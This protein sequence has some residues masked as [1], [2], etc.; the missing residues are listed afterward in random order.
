MTFSKKSV[1]LFTV[2]GTGHN[3][4]YLNIL[5]KAMLIKEYHITV[6]L[7]QSC[8]DKDSYETYIKPFKEHLN[9]ILHEDKFSD[10][11]FKN[12]WSECQSL[13]NAI[14][15]NEKKY[16]AIFAPN[17]SQIPFLWPIFSFLHKSKLKNTPSVLFGMLSTGLNHA[18]PSI[19]TRIDNLARKILISLNKKGS[20]NTIDN[21]AFMKID[22][23]S[24]FLRQRF[25]IIPDPMDTFP[26]IDKASARVYFGISDDDFVVSISGAISAHPRKN[27]QLLIN[28]L[29]NNALNKR[30][31]LLIGGSLSLDLEQE[32]VGSQAVIDKKIIINNRYLT[33]QELTTLTCASD[34][35]C[36]PYTEHFAPSGIVLRAIKCN[37][38]VLV[39]N[40][41][42]FKFM[43][44]T[45][46]IGWTLDELTEN[47][48]VK[49]INSIALTGQQISNSSLQRTLIKH[50]FSEDNF[51]AHWLSQ[52][53]ADESVP[54]DFAKFM[55]DYK[56]T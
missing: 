17:G 40:Y 30:I 1:L 12:S 42:W 45:F 27:S 50:Y 18:T 3:L 13:A 28:A 56:A 4:I 24:R 51:A 25:N 55:M 54:Y 46:N 19:K 43:V 2:H 38:P 31:C 16:D 36:T 33:D 52:I 14:L 47:A 41:H 9:F 15:T 44:D 34:L 7:P 20:I 26:L 32:L 35:V 11:L 22:S 8:I 21:Y 29:S 49:A 53:E 6:A 10:S 48:I 5:I 23:H 37:V 39:P